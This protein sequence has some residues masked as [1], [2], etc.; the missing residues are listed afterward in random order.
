MMMISR[1]ALTLALAAGSLVPFP[2]LANKYP[3]RPI[4]MIVPLAPGSPVDVVARL[5]AQNL[6][7]DLKQNVVVENR[8][9]AGTTIGMKAVA[10]SE[11]DGHTLLFQS[12]SLVVA[13]AMYKNFD[14]DPVKAFAPVA[15]VA[16]G[17]W[18]TVVPP[19]F[20]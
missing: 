3:T 16:W 4:K 15:N 11:P 1:R 10:T 6:S 7:V 8:P 13:P 5:L 9:G 14:Y 2:A 20:R 17:S 19:G 12:S 18:V